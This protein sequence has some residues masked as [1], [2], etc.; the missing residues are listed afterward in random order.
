MNQ[1]Q[2]DSSK[3]SKQLG[4]MERFAV[5]LGNLAVT[6]IEFGEAMQQ[7][8]AVGATAGANPNFGPEFT[9]AG[10][11]VSQKGETFA[12]VMG[13]FGDPH[14]RTWRDM[15]TISDPSGTEGVVL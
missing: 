11:S 13:T 5:D 7:M 14:G 9:A 10:D 2:F 8:V 3:F 15:Q 12:K 1:D 6:A 4:A